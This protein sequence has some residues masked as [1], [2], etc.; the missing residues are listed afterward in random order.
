MSAGEC[1]PQAAHWPR[2]RQATVSRERLA[3]RETVSADAA[4]QDGTVDQRSPHIADLEN[5][6]QARVA[7]RAQTPM[8]PSLK[9]DRRDCVRPWS[10]RNNHR[11]RAALRASAA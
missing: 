11:P 7:V 5:A 6:K 1:A 10:P 3:L 8:I 9:A 4:R 2:R